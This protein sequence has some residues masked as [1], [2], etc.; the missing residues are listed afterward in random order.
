[1]PCHAIPCHAMP[2]HPIP[3]HP[4]PSHPF[5]PVGR[6]SADWLRVHSTKRHVVTLHVQLLLVSLR[7]CPC[8]R[9]QVGSGQQV[10]RPQ[11]HRAS[12]A[13]RPPVDQPPS[14]GPFPSPPW[15]PGC[16][17]SPDG[18]WHGGSCR[19]CWRGCDAWGTRDGQFPAEVLEQR[20]R[21]E[22][23]PGGGPRPQTR[24]GG[25]APVLGPA[26]L[27]PA[28]W[29]DCA[30]GP[31]AP[32]RPPAQNSFS[33]AFQW[34]LCAIPAGKVPPRGPPAL[35]RPPAGR[36]PP[37]AGRGAGKDALCARTRAA[38]LGCAG[39]VRAEPDAGS[40]RALRR[41]ERAAGSDSSGGTVGLGRRWRWPVP[42]LSR[43]VGWGSLWGAGEPR[44]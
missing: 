38:L 26:P 14:R 28:Q 41:G 11:L 15:W 18:G 2:S 12:P 3:S 20:A 22:A 40:P 42:S 31:A 27:P 44:R 17:R 13:G 9:V 30:P 39:N 19:R 33:A 10:R 7:G 29:P 37:A 36:D 34:P 4:I 32:R 16:P 24:R 1:M 25:K 35:A 6:P 43:E 21:A 8:P 23:L 5:P